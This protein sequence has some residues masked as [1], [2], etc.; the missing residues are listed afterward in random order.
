MKNS[1]MLLVTL[2]ALCLTGVGWSQDAF[3]YDSGDRRD[4]FVPVVSGSG[5]I[6]SGE[7]L[8]TSFENIT[9]GGIIYD[10]RN[11][12]N[13]LALINGEPY[14][15]GARV[16]EFVIVNIESTKVILRVGEEEFSLELVDEVK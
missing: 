4:P 3:L 15:V 14:G 11:P 8:N 9:L 5:R 10:A 13:S 6:L 16:M 12:K 2:V 7:K 1:V